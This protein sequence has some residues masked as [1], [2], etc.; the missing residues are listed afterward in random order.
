MQTLASGSPALR[1]SGPSPLA[2]SLRQSACCGVEVD[3]Q[4]PADPSELCQPEL[5]DTLA[6]EPLSHCIALNVG[7]V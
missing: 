7:F 6:T 1:L 4:C 2:E 3:V 5:N